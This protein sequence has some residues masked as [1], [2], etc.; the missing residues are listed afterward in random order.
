MTAAAPPNLWT[1]GEAAAAEPDAW[2]SQGGF[3]Q[4][5]KHVQ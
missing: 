4:K 5:S 2:A 3:C 1:A